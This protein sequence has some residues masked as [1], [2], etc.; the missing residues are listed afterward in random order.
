MLKT[1]GPLTTL[2]ASG[3]DLYGSVAD[4]EANYRGPVGGI[5]HA[6]DIVGY[7]DDPAVQSG[8]YWIIKNSWGSWS[9]DN[10]YYYVPY[11]NLEVHNGTN[12]LTGPVYYNGAMD[13]VTW[14][15][16]TN[17]TWST[18]SSMSGNWSNAGTAYKWVNQETAATFDATGTNRTIS[19]SGTAIAHGLT[20]S[21]GAT[22]YSFT[23]GGLTVTVGGITAQES[24]T[25][26][27]PITIG[28]PQSWNVTSGKTLT[29]GAVHTVI[30]DLT[31]NGA[32][33][34]VIS[35]AIDGGGVINTVGGVRAGQ[36][37]PSRHGNLDDFRSK[38]E[39]CRQHYRERGCG[40]RSFSRRSSGTTA[41]L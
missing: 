4:M 29:V 16:T 23:G 2:V 36:F 13:S 9:G 28:G 20:F 33:N 18:S 21:A 41:D 15:G 32:G 26:D 35:G 6:V 3:S 22:D 38:H 40:Q 19:I 10:G 39:L 12:A 8:G 34:T 14:K 17:G 11:G 37:D 7:A 1:Y 24:V 5:D 31:I 25:I 30:S 27:S